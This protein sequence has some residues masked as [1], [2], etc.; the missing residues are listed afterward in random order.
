MVKI[1]V[2]DDLYIK[3]YDRGYMVYTYKGDYETTDGTREI[4]TS[5][6]FFSDIV[7]AVNFVG[8]RK[9]LFCEATSFKE[10]KQEAEKITKLLQEIREELKIG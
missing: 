7:S 4:T 6:A 5:L 9:L 3:S 2:T 8:Q 10:Y 1:K